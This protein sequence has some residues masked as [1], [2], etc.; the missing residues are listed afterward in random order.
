MAKHENSGH[1]SAKIVADLE[2]LARLVRAS[3]HRDG[4][5]PA[6]WE[7]LRYLARANRFSNSP[8]ALTRYLGATKGT[9]SQTLKS[10]QAKGYLEK[11]PRDGK[12]GSISLILTAKAAE[13]LLTDP[14]ARL[15]GEVATLGGKT[16]RRLGKGLSEVLSGELRRKGEPQ[17]GHCAECR[18]FREQ[19]RGGDLRVCMLLDEEL[20]ETDTA[21]ICVEFVAAD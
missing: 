16:R 19:G 3:E 2:R 5:N 21:L 8:G 20:T 14:W 13:A 4:L 6:Q 1:E 15:A 10:L 9:V 18:Y 17:F 12:R 11:A 7:A